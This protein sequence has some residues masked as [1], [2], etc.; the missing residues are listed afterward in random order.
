MLTQLFSPLVS[1]AKPLPR[2]ERRTALIEATIPLLTEHGSAVSTRQVAQAAQ[3]AEGTIFRVF[4]SKDALVQ[5]SILHAMREDSIVEQLRTVRATDLATTTVELVTLI[6]KYIRRTHTLITLAH[7]LHV[8]P[9]WGPHHANAARDSHEKPA[10]A[11][12]ADHG[13]K[14]GLC[15]RRF[16]AA[17][18]AAVTESLSRHAGEL[19]PHPK[20]AS[21]ALISLTFGATH[22]F[23]GHPDIADPTTIA[24]LLLNGITKDA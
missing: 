10:T 14:D 7:E 23:A 2:D 21:S 4:E 20:F 12:A 5:A 9:A 13:G 24:D 3:V 1:R 6:A 16:H 19:R 22:P 17:I 8:E 15:P 11:K 18:T